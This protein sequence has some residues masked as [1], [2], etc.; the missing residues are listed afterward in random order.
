MAVSLFAFKSPRCRQTTATRLQGRTSVDG[1]RPNGMCDAWTVRAL[2]FFSI[3]L[4]NPNRLDFPKLG[5]ANWWGVGQA[6]ALWRA[7]SLF[8][9]SSPSLSSGHFQRSTIWWLWTMKWFRNSIP[10]NQVLT[11]KYQQLES[12]LLSQ[13][14]PGIQQNGHER[15]WGF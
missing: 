13:S 7:A 6:P 9:K 2:W 11:T 15:R 5:Q 1:W 8:W 3:A 10:F 4:L 12:F 14:A